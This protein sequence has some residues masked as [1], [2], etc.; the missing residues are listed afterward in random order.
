MIFIRPPG[1]DNR[2]RCYSISACLCP[3]LD[4]TKIDSQIKDAGL[5]NRQ[6]KQVSLYLERVYSTNIYQENIYCVSA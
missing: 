6:A 3:V 5:K 1:V 4:S 2:A